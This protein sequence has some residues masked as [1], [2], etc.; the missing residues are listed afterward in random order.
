MKCYIITY[1]LRFAK[2]YE[3]LIDKIKKYPRWAKITESTWAIVTSQSAS[4]I[5][6]HLRMYMDEDDRL[7]VIKSGIEA[8]WKNVMASNEWLKE[9]LIK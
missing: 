2:N 6:N 8:A 7:F 3:S 1:D 4:D 5:R 9:N